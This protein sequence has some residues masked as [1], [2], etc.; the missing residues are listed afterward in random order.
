MSLADTARPN[1]SA[2]PGVLSKFPWPTTRRMEAMERAPSMNIPT[3]M[4]RLHLS[5]DRVRAAPALSPTLSMNLGLGAIGL[6]V[7]GFFFPKHVARTLGIRAPAPVVQGLFGL[8]ELWTGFT[9]AGDP[10][11]SEMLWTRVAGDVFDL[12]VLRMLDNRRN[13]KRGVARAALGFV[14]AAAALDLLAAIRMSDVQR[15][16]A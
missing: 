8:R 16:R 5:T 12:A 7:W 3:P 2:A 9:L 13:P 4:G 10:T 15:S 6:G 11:K 1:G 14:L